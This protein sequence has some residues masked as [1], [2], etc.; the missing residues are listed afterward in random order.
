MDFESKLGEWFFD[1]SGSFDEIFFGEEDEGGV[2]GVE[3]IFMVK[4]SFLFGKNCNSGWDRFMV[5]HLQ[6]GAWFRS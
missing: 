3:G 2:V 1:K 5:D 6:Y 4:A